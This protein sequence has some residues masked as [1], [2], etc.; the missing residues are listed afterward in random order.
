[1]V[2][3]MKPSISALDGVV[4]FGVVRRTSLSGGSLVEGLSPFFADVCADVS[5]NRACK[6]RISLSFSIISALRRK[7]VLELGFECQLLLSRDVRLVLE[8]VLEFG[9]E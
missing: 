9:F 8:L 4:V 6:R 7:L 5:F 1:M 3:E 2:L